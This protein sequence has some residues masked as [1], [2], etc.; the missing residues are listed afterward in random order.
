VDERDTFNV[1][2][3]SDANDVLTV[4]LDG[5]L[6]MA[7]AGWVEESLAAAAPHHRRMVIELHKLTFID[8]TG[9]RTLLVLRQRADAAGIRIQFRKP[10]AEVMR[11]LT[12]AGLT[13][14]LDN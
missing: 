13:D 9:I 3:Q 14:I 8:S 10:S 1:E 4:V 6:D 5:E 2:M 11:T 12:S 7:D